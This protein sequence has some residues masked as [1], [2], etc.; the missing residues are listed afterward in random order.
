MKKILLLLSLILCIINFINAQEKFVIEEGSMGDKFSYV[1]SSQD[2]IFLEK[3]DSLYQLYA[4]INNEFLTIFDTISPN[5][6][7]AIPSVK[8]YLD[9][10]QTMH[11][12]TMQHLVAN[13]SLR[14]FLYSR[15]KLKMDDVGWQY[16][17]EDPI[18]H[19]MMVNYLLQSEVLEKC[20]FFDYPLPISHLKYKQYGEE[21][22]L[23]QKLNL[24][25][26]NIAPM[27]YFLRGYKKEIAHRLEYLDEE[28]DSCAYTNLRELLKFMPQ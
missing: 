27:A 17:V 21:L 1:L 9:N 10:L 25:N 14:Y 19:K 7:V 12:S 13:D 16:F 8:K 18:L 28:S 6:L 15:H 5:P 26:F 24:N 11:N 23:L 22:Q 4:K 2:S 3:F 20:N